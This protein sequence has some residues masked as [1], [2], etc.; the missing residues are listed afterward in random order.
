MY[1]M[2]SVGGTV[3]ACYIPG[4][5]RI[6]NK[7]QTSQDYS[8]LSAKRLDSLEMNFKRS[9]LHKPMERFSNHNSNEV[10]VVW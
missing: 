2:I 3:I 7:K 10:N 5:V 9:N 4:Y 1:V 8:F 6:F